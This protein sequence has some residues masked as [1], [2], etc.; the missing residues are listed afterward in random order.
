MIESVQRELGMNSTLSH[1]QFPNVAWP[2]GGLEWVEL[3]PVC[4]S[5]H[6]ELLHE[7]L[8]DSLYCAPGDWALY[9]CQSCGSGYLDPRPTLETIGLAYARYYTHGSVWRQNADGHGRLSRH[10]YAMAN[11]YLNERFGTSFAPA[12]RLGPLLA[13]FSPANRGRLETLGRQMPKA[14]PNARLLDIGCG[15]GEFL[16]FARN[17]GWVVS[18]VET[19]PKAVEH[20][21]RASLDIHQGGIEALAGQSASFDAI[22]L[23]HVIEHVHDPLALLRACYRLL[24]PRGWIWVATPN[25]ESQGHCRFGASWRGLEPPRHL[26][27]LTRS[28][29]F[30]LMQTAGFQQIKDG[31]YWPMCADLFAKSEAIIRGED[32]QLTRPSRQYRLKLLAT[33]LRARLRPEIRELITLTARKEL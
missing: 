10:L 31:P 7:R 32:F 8:T 6:R 9:C 16:L 18:G 23:S 20:C 5:E 13:Q 29:I 12:N 2:A 21:R 19:D 25:L 3:C 4:G 14:T 30:Y 26:V 11:S 24:R 17:A 27:L 22:T 33:E 1:Q 28:S 15:N